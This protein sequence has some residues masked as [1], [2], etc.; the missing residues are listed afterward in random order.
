MQRVAIRAMAQVLEI[1]LRES[2]REDLGGTYSVSASAGYSKIPREEYTVTIAFGCSPDR[3]DELIKSVFKEIE[4]LK[5]E[6]ADRQA[7]RRREGD[8]PA[9]SGNQHEAERLSARP[10]R[11]PLSGRE[12]L[13]SL[14]NWRTTTTRSMPATVRDAARLVL[15]ADN[16]VKVTLF[17]E[18]GRGAGAA[19]DRRAA[20]IR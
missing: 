20:T 9:R 13:T 10:D 15:K 17:P 12:D 14:F 11:R 4:Q 19:S 1:R 18:K 5:T 2:L 6:R 8:V 16:L 7:G 3:T